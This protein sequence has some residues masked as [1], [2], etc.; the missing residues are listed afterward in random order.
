[1]KIPSAY[2]SWAEAVNRRS[3]P[4]KRSSKTAGSLRDHIPVMD[5][6]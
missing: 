3:D 4:S 6:H 2:G 1:M 5:P